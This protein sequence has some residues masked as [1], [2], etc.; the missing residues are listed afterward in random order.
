MLQKQTRVT[1]SD[2]SGVAWLQTF[3]IYRGSWRRYATVGDFIKTSVKLVVSYPRYVRGKSYKPL[4]V[5]YIVRGLCTNVTAWSRFLDNTR[6]RFFINSVVLL[7]KRG[8]FRSK[9]IYTP[10]LR[11]I[12]KKRY[13]SIFHY[14]F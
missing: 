6:V 3:H 14:I 9:Y 1:V 12:R 8:V 13:R 5:G 4:R 7:K 2:G 10:L 11:V